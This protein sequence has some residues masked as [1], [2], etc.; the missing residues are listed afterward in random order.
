MLALNKLGVN[1]MRKP[2]SYY[3]HVTKFTRIVCE[4]KSLN[5]KRVRV[6]KRISHCILAVVENTFNIDAVISKTST[7]WYTALHS[8]GQINS[9]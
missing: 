9:M 5:H 8:L 2:L 4:A 6:K 1:N 7:Y 3:K